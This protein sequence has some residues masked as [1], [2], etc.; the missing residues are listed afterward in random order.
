[1][2]L[3]DFIEKY[4]GEYLDW[5]GYPPDDPYQCFDLFRFYVHEVWNLP[6]FPPTGDQGAKV[7]YDAVDNQYIKVDNTPQG[8][9]QKGDV[10]IYD[11]RAGGGF[12]H[13]S[14]FISG[15]TNNFLCFEQNRP[16][17]SP[18][19]VGES[20]YAAVRGWFRPDIMDAP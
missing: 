9:P 15:D 8:V 3:D 13:V 4:D 6:Q 20:S 14:I 19:H 5:D 11:G 10:V 2:N 1:M 12:G 17:G 18:C 16:T 7:I